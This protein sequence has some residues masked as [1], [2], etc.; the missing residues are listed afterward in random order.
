MIRI[1]VK[2]WFEEA[3]R[4]DKEANADLKASVL[5]GGVRVDKFIDNLMK[6]FVQAE[7]LC[8]QKGLTLK[9]KT[10]QDATYD[11]TKMFLNATEEEARRR[12]ESDY[13]KA[14]RQAKI[15]Q[16]KEFDAVLA[17]RPEGEFAEAGVISND[18]IDQEREDGIN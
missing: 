5:R 17:G 12:Y 11:M 10:I 13:Q 15:N 14:M 2:K 3:V 1:Q 8:K 9:Q 6:E 7:K 18:K 16:E 4:L